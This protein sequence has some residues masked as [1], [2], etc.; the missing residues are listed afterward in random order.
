VDGISLHRFPNKSCLPARRTASS[1]N[2]IHIWAIPNSWRVGHA[3]VVFF[4]QTPDPSNPWRCV[5]SSQLTL[6]GADLGGLDR[7]HHGGGRFSRCLRCRDV[8]RTPGPDAALTEDVALPNAG[9]SRICPTVDCRRAAFSVVNAFAPYI[10]VPSVCRQL[11][12]SQFGR[13]H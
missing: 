13:V 12:G 9:A 2:R 3:M 6:R 1:A 10:G 8:R 7:G 11:S 5:G 4:T